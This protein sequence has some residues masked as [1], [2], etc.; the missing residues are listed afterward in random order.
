[1]LIGCIIRV[2]GRVRR[3]MGCDEKGV[4]RGC[5]KRVY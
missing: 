4:L 2:I 3:L 1:M 5:V